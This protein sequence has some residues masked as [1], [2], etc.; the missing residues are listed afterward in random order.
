MRRTLI[1]A[2]IEGTTPLSC[3]TKQ[4]ELGRGKIIQVEIINHS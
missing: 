3:Y 1:F 2:L 4:Q